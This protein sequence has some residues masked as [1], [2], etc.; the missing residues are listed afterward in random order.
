MAQIDELR[1]LTRVARLYHERGLTQPQIASQLSIS[2]AKVSRLLSRAQ[3]EQIVRITI[4]QPS[5]VFAELEDD[6]E[7]RYGLNEVI[8]ADC[9]DQAEEKE[10]QHAIGAAAAYYV[11]TT[12]TPA[13]IVG[14]SSWSATL[15]AMV[16]AMAHRPK[17]SGAR[18]VQILGGIGN[19][20]ANVH[21]THLTR[22]LAASLA[23]EPV[24]LP[25]PGILSTKELRAAF[26]SDPFVQ[27]ATRL[28]DQ[29]TLALVG[30]GSVEPS[31]T[32]ASS[33][34]VFL[35]HELDQLRER[36]A[37]GD[38]CLRFIDGCGKPVV[39]PLDE[40]VMGMTLAQLGKVKRSVG[41]AGGQRKYEAIRAAVRGHWVNVL[42]TDRLI[43]ERLV[44]EQG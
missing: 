33:G 12:M 30:I 27:Q 8:I 28:F 7:R 20:G 19:P 18:V 34:N 24:F 6:L 36:G 35:P 22:R 14:I 43:G 5:G 1:L 39:T 11:E 9:A 3:A 38:L 10:V 13:E 44:Q 2:Q 21:A 25:A 4:N 37:V 32:L 41:I 29:T 40:R 23:G 15:L 42:I 31:S 17:P 16:D 26:A